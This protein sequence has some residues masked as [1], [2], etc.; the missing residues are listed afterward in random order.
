MKWYLD[1]VIYIYG[2]VEVSFFIISESFCREGAGSDSQ[3]LEQEPG[4]QEGKDSHSF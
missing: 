4:R 3:C 2:P 1:M